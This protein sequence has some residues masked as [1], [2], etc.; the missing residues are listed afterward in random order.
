MRFIRGHN[1]FGMDRSKPYKEVRYLAEDRGF[2]SEC[3]IW[4]LKTTTKTGYGVVR[5]G[6]KDLLAHRWHYEQV[7]GPIPVGLQIDHLCRVRDCVNPDHMQ[8]VS[9][10]E[11][12]RRSLAGKVT[13]NLQDEMI[14]AL[15]M[16]GNFSNAE[17]GRRFGVTR[18]TVR[19]IKLRGAPNTR[20]PQRET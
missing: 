7:N 6:G 15:A 5:V 11:N 9:P 16:T 13:S 20:R 3:W 19:L 17:I 12:T 18:E 1:S 8:V 4:Q 10:Q 14:Y 2:K